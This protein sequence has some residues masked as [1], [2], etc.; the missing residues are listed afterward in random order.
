MLKFT[1]DKK[2]GKTIVQRKTTETRKT[3]SGKTYVV[4]DVLGFIERSPIDLTAEQK[5]YSIAED[6]TQQQQYILT[7][8]CADLANVFSS[9]YT[10][11][12]SSTALELTEE[13]QAEVESKTKELTQYYKATL[14]EWL[15]VN[16]DMVNMGL[17]F[18]FAND[19]PHQTDIDEVLAEQ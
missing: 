7:H 14:R 4:Y 11:R 18:A 17:N 1:F 6:V 12:A 10:F 9:E 3:T 2:T 5:R 16:R 15:K 13:E 19:K 8:V